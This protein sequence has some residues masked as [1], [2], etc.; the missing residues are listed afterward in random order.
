MKAS[1]SVIAVL[2]S[3]LVAT[4]VAAPAN[5]AQEWHPGTIERSTVS[6]C[7]FD[8]ETGII[9]NA[10]FESDPGSVPKVGEVFYVRTIPGRVG[11]G[12]GTGISVHVEIVP[13]AGVSPAISASTPVRCNYMDI[14]T[15]VLAP[16]SGCPQEP[17]AGVYG[18][19]FDQLTPGGSA[20]TS[21]WDLP[22]GKALVIEIPLRSSH[23]LAGAPPA[24]I[25]SNGEPPCAAN[26]AGDS[27][28]FA[29]KVIDGFGS[30]WLSPYVGLF[31]APSAAGG[32]SGTGELIVAAPRAIQISRLLSGLAITVNVAEGGSSVTAK[33]SVKVLG[34]SPAKVKIIATRTVRDVAAGTLA[35]KLKP[36]RAAAR[37]LRRARRPL[38]ATLHVRLTPPQG[39]PHTATTNVTLRP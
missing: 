35:M 23:E 30:P 37:S 5:A 1:G 17:Q 3:A 27:L 28:Q 20:Q 10:E 4:L 21:P 19:A 22:Y 11:N 24:C 34:A 7:N 39:G 31:V 25:R 26:Q 8:P 15:G 12:C 33:L 36:S 2:V 13:P 18:V 14:D 32:G 16:A 38:T 29:D 6:N 9:A